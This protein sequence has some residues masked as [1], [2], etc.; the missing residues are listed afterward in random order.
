MVIF[1]VYPI[2]IVHPTLMVRIFENIIQI[3]NKVVDVFFDYLD[4]V[5]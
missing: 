5:Y 2:F 1:S 4:I 3:K